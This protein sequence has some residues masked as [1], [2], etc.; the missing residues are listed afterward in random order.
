MPPGPDPLLSAELAEGRMQWQQHAR[1]SLPTFE[2]TA[3]AGK[4]PLRLTAEAAELAFERA[5]DG[6]GLHSGRVVLTNGAVRAP[7]HQ[8]RSMGIAADMHLSAAGLDPAQRI[9]FD[10]IDRARRRAALVRAAPDRRGATQKRQGRRLDLEL[11]RPGRRWGCACAGST[12]SRAAAGHAK[13]DLSPVRPAPDRLQPT[14]WRRC[15]ASWTTYPANCAARCAWL[16]RRRGLRTDLD[17]LVEDLAFSSG[18]AR[19]AQVNGVIAFDRLAPLSTPPGQQLAIGLVDVGL[20]LT[21]G[22]LTFDLE[23][24]QLGVVEQLAWQL[25]QGRIRAAP[26][27]IGSADMRF[28]TTLTAERLNLDEIFALAQLDGLSGEGTMHGT[29]PITIAGAEAVI[30][31][32]ELVSDRPGWVRYRPKQPPAAL[33]AGGRTS[34][35]CFRPWRTSATKTWLTIDGR[36]DGEMDNSLHIAGANPDPLL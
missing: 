25:A 21:D 29:L 30:E 26:F 16:G 7:A 8:L 33:E 4:M 36:T 3:S 22:L 20:P 31:H 34:T 19:F 24:G 13:L 11:G 2:V 1:A 27:T 32:G 17:L 14:A 10:R 28:A 5:G 15:W 35:C 18:P 23:L 12:I 9:G 6:Q